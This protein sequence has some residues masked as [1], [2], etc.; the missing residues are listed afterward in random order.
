M[1]ME[2]ESV[3][4][5]VVLWFSAGIFISYGLTCLFLPDVPARYAGLNMTNGNAIAEIS[6]MYGGLQTGFGLFCLLGA[7][8]HNF[9]KSGLVLLVLCIGSLALARIFSTLVI[10]DPVSAYTWGAMIYEFATA[11]LAAL[12][13]RKVPALKQ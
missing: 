2:S 6:A 4:G 5:K 1:N 10:T 3:L 8:N 7:L 9:Y 11:I 12:A 13:L